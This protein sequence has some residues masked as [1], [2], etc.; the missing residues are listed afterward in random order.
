MSLDSYIAAPVFGST[1]YGNSSRPRARARADDTSARPSGTPAPSR[2]DRGSRAPRAP[3]DRTDTP[4]TRRARAAAPGARPARRRSL[5][6]QAAERGEHGGRHVERTDHDETIRIGAHAWRTRPS[7]AS[8]STARP[9][10][11]RARRRVRAPLRGRARVG[12][13]Q[14]GA[15]RSARG[16]GRGARRGAARGAARAALGVS[17]DVRDA[18][19]LARFLDA[20]WDEFGSL[21]VLV[22]N[23]GIEAGAQ[24]LRDDRRRTGTMSSTP[25]SRALAGVEALHRARGRAR[26]GPGEHRE[27]RLDHGLPTIKGQLPYAVSKAA[28]IK[29]TEVMALEAAKFSIRVNAIAPG[30]ILTWRAARDPADGRVRETDPS[31]ATSGSRTSTARS[32]CSPP[33]P[34]AGRRA[35]RSSSTRATMRGTVKL[36]AS[37]SR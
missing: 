6:A 20:A 17:L 31:A 4:R 23:A 25:T 29:A 8:G 12:G 27:R 19:C 14:R 5:R 1:R 11:S 33:T 35:R 22:N 36:R 18:A 15:G 21:D 28:L 34:R 7:T 10:R 3:C 26:P 32:C 37:R 30:Y 9:S 16:E 13:R 24:D 2:R